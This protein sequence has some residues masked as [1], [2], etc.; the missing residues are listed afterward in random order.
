MKA[1]GDGSS[2]ESSFTVSL[3][4]L[5]IMNISDHHTRIKVS[6]EGTVKVFG[7]LFGT[8]EGRNAEICD[9]FELVVKESK[10][11]YQLDVDYFVFKREQCK[12]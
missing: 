9:S 1:K 8:H 7:A 2:S 6:M 3:H 12:Q 4:P 10:S 11:G 5:V